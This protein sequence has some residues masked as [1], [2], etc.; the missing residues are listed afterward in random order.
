M[1]EVGEVLEVEAWLKHHRS[2]GQRRSRSVML[3]LHSARVVKI[4]TFTL[5]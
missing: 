3:I 5:S 2:K 4:E 1:Q